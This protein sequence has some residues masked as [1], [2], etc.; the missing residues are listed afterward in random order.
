MQSPIRHS[1][2]LLIVAPSLAVLSTTAAPTMRV[3]ERP[4]QARPLTACSV[5]D[6]EQLKQVT[7]RQD[8]M[9]RGPRNDDPETPA[10]GRTGCV[11]LGFIFELNAP[12]KPEWFDETRSFLGK[13][14]KIQ[15]VSGVGDAAFYWWDPRAGSAR[16]VGIVL[17]T[18]TNGLLI[19][20]MTSSDS[21]E[22]VKPELLAVAKAIVPRLR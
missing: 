3:T 8:P 10:P 13:R 21:I 16:P 22:V 1:L 7:R 18:A 15:P 17:R 11:Y 9:K 12:A 14:A 4:E 5:I 2:G 19:M 6:A 20:D